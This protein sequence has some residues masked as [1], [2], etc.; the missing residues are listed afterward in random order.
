MQA[1]ALARPKLRGTT[2]AFASRLFGG[3][4]TK[5]SAL[6]SLVIASFVRSLSGPRR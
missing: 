6:E 1:V 3:R 2:V 4:V 5:T